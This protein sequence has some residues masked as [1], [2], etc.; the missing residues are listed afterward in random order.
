MRGTR[1][2]GHRASR[3]RCRTRRFRVLSE[4]PGSPALRRSRETRTA[5]CDNCDL[6]W[7][8]PPSLF[9]L[10][11]LW[12]GCFE[13]PMESS[14]SQT[15]AFGENCWSRAEICGFDVTEPK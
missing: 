5:D 8:G 1:C 3:I 9:R 13:A 12:R 15:D 7:I 6:V 2:R 14:P 4:A 11:Y 10:D